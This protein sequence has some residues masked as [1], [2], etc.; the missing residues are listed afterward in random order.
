VVGARRH[1]GVAA[2][3]CFVSKRGQARSDE[4]LVDRRGIEVVVLIF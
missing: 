4:P 3:K 2:V 1:D